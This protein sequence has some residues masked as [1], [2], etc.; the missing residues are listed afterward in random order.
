MKLEDAKDLGERLECLTSSEQANCKSF[1]ILLRE[2]DHAMHMEQQVKA[3][4][5]SLSEPEAVYLAMS[6]RRMIRV[7]M[8]VA[9]D[10]NVKEFM[11]L[12]E[13]ELEKRRIEKH[14]G[15]GNPTRD[16]FINCMHVYLEEKLKKVR[17]AEEDERA[18]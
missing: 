2:L 10:D 7:L 16:K 18:A 9:Q 4:D 8:Q 15:I 13:W 17:E 12:Q 11:N 1:L 3:L 6:R 5:V 14:G